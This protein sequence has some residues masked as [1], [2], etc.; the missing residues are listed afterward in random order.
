[1]KTHE[2]EHFTVNL[3]N[4]NSVALCV[5]RDQD[6]G[7]GSVLIK[8]DALEVFHAL[9]MAVCEILDTVTKEGMNK[10]VAMSG[11]RAAFEAGVK[12]YVKYDK[13]VQ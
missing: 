8:G 11:V 1:M 12:T 2:T 4:E 9:G 7:D 6:A 5:I 13:E 10:H 3:K